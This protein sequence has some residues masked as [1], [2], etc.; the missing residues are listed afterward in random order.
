MSV[1]IDQAR[2]D[3]APADIHLAGPPG[4]LEAGTRADRL[5]LSSANHDGRVRERRYSRAVDQR[6]AHQRQAVGGRLASRQQ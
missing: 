2:D 6:R 5:E 3:P 4:K 1:G